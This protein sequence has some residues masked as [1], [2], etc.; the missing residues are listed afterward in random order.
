MS[1]DSCYE[2]ASYILGQPYER[3]SQIVFDPACDKSIH[4]SI[5]LDYCAQGS[6]D[7]LNG[8]SVYAFLPLGSPG[9]S[10]S[11]PNQAETGETGETF[12]EN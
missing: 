1:S 9:R 2:P 4:Y 6:I 5:F 8:I 12:G 10:W 11:L 7:V 3:T